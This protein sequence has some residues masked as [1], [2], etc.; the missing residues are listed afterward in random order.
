MSRNELKLVELSNSR[1]LRGYVTVPQIT[2]A[3]ERIRSGSPF[4]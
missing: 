3:A 4:R 2:R 1:I